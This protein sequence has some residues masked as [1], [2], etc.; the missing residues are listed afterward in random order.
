MSEE[1]ELLENTEENS[2][3]CGEDCGC[4]SSE[5]GGC[6]GGCGGCG[7][8]CGGG[9]PMVR[10]QMDDGTIVVCQMMGIFPCDNGREYIALAPMDGPDAGKGGVYLYRY[11]MNDQGETGLEAIETQ[12][13]FDQ[14]AA[15]LKAIQNA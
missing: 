2:C 11:G 14:A 13:E 1:K 7:G 5:E 8:G 15:A 12:E 6:G 3:G 9:V 10:L 4:G